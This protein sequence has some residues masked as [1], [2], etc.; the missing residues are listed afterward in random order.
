MKLNT[1][2]CFS[3]QDTN[4]MAFNQGHNSGFL[5]FSFF[6]FHF[7]FSFSFFSS[8]LLP[9]LHPLVHSSLKDIAHFR[10]VCYLFSALHVVGGLHS[11]IPS[12]CIHACGT[13][14]T[15]LIFSK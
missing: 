15:C 13:P 14:Y 11:N 7:S 6:I 2:S 9:M 10:C 12:W 4:L 3:T 1:M 8:P 5:F